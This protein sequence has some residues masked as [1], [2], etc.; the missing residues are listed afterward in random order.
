MELEALKERRKGYT[1][2]FGYCSCREDDLDWLIQQVETFGKTINTDTGTVGHHC[3]TKYDPPITTVRALMDSAEEHI[4][5]DFTG[6]AM[7][8]GYHSRLGDKIIKALLFEL[9]AAICDSCYLSELFDE[10][11]ILKETVEELEG[12]IEARNLGA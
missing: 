2:A 3:H 4:S 10:N 12:D 8:W 1:T 7:S 6:D 9:D 5:G 11:K